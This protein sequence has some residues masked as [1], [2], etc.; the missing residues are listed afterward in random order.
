MRGYLKNLL[1]LETY[2]YGKFGITFIGN[3]VVGDRPCVV[4]ESNCTF[5]RNII[6][7]SRYDYI[8]YIISKAHGIDRVIICD[9]RDD[10]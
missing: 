6:D 5:Y 1:T 10:V 7:A 8:D 2:V 3:Y 4:S 9:L